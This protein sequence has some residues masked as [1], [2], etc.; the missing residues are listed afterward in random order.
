MM[1]SRVLVNTCL[2]TR[3]KGGDMKR[4]R[5]IRLQ[6]FLVTRGHPASLLFS[7]IKLQHYAPSTDVLLHDTP[8]C[9][10]ILLMYPTYHLT[11]FSQSTHS[12]RLLCSFCSV[13]HPFPKTRISKSQNPPSTTTSPT[14]QPKNTLK[15]PKNHITHDHIVHCNRNITVDEQNAIIVKK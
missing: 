3:R 14:S 15:Y 2:A 4:S 1:L 7:R 10:A 12:P 13:H 9:L 8:M 5:I 11:H 6:L